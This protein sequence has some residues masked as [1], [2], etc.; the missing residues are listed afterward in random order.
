MGDFLCNFKLV[1]FIYT[2]VEL[3]DKNIPHFHTII[4]FKSIIGFNDILKTNL[5]KILNNT[6]DFVIIDYYTYL[7][8]FKLDSLN[9]FI[10]I[11]KF[12]NYILKDVEKYK[13]QHYAYINDDQ[14]E[15]T[16]KIMLTSLRNNNI[17][18]NCSIGD[19]W[20]I[21]PSTK[22][23]ADYYNEFTLINLINFYIIFKN[24]KWDKN[25]VYCKVEDLEISYKELNSLDNFLNDINNIYMELMV[26]FP[27]HLENLDL[28]S[29][30]LKYFAKAL[31]LINDPRQI[32]V[33]QTKINFDYIEFSDGIYNI[34]KD[35]FLKKDFNKDWKN[36]VHI[37][38]KYLPN[39]KI[40]DIVKSNIIT[41]KYYNLTFKHTTATLPNVWLK[42]LNLVV[43]NESEL[44]SLITYFGSLFNNSTELL[45]KQRVLYVYG[46]PNTKK[47]I[48]TAKVLTNFFG[49]KNI[50]YISK[51]KTFS[52]ENILG[53]E[54]AIF[55]EFEH[56]NL[57]IDITLKLLE[58]TEV[59]ID[60]K[61]KQ[62][63]LLKT[64]RILIISNNKMS[65]KLPDIIKKAID[66]RINYVEFKTKIHSETDDLIMKLEKEEP[67]IVTYCNK[68][69]IKKLK[70]KQKIIIE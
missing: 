24:L 5:I 15:N 3:N 28:Y 36:P 21:L 65:S 61:F 31:A 33:N 18:I 7:F 16:F 17:F 30:K 40:N 4:G 1:S 25:Q 23:Q 55:D 8:D 48:L 66:S 19:Q 6:K 68:Y 69:F 52:L 34:K 2:A 56:Y 10:D 9:K 62:S 64:I 49:L 51:N 38:K 39:T 47:T 63:E 67:F 43:S 59:L 29:I 14:L 26:N 35:L 41:I 22:K 53:K 32:L 20:K 54:I 58:G 13:T 60:K 45:G 70:K 50:G 57:P 46:E 44:D 12:F 27:A 11:K 37:N 42:E